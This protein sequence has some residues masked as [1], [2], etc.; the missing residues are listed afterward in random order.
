IS[1]PGREYTKRILSIFFKTANVTGVAEYFLLHALLPQSLLELYRLPPDDDACLGLTRRTFQEVWDDLAT[2]LLVL[3][4]RT[5]DAHVIVT[6]L[7]VTLKKLLSQNR[8]FVTSADVSSAV[9]KLNKIKV[10][11][12]KPAIARIEK[13]MK[14]LGRMNASS[15][16]KNV[17]EL[18]R[19]AV[20][21]TADDPLDLQTS[22]R[23]MNNRHTTLTISSE[24]LKPPFYCH[25]EYKFLNYATL[26]AASAE[27]LLSALDGPF[28]VDRHNAS[29]DYSH[30]TGAKLE[31]IKQCLALSVN[32]IAADVTVSET[33][34][35]QLMLSV[36]AFQLALEASLLG[37]VNDSGVDDV[38]EPAMDQTF[39]AR[40]CQ[41]LCADESDASSVDRAPPNVR[42]NVAVMNSPRFTT[43]FRCV[44]EDEM[45]PSRQCSVL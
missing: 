32:R 3:G 25:G 16:Y 2:Y 37:R 22:P 11:L 31:D 43:L 17:L 28:A 24:A 29:H 18:G 38:A 42:C 40:Y 23:S 5:G 35:R 27:A 9:D 8:L 36:G 4:D 34:L 10:K 44:R 13:R 41:S 20:N 1:V 39:F 6:N 19:F 33:W 7:T 30:R 15:L 26:G 12:P 45:T 14:G 21:R